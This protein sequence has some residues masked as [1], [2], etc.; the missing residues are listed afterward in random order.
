ML[1]L[2]PS[3]TA[4]TK[5]PE[6]VVV[7][8]DGFNLYYG[9]REK[10]WKHLYW[11]NLRELILRLQK[12]NQFLS[13]VKYFTTRVS[14]TPSD[15]DKP[16]RQK[17]FL[18]ALAT[19]PDMELIYGHYLEKS[20]TCR[21]CGYRWTIHE[22]K[23]T[24]VN[25]AVQMLQDAQNDLFDTAFLVSADSD[26]FGPVQAIRRGYLTKRVVVAFPPARR[27]A[28][29][30]SIAHAHLVI[31]RAQLTKSQFPDQV[32]KLDGFVLERPEQWKQPINLKTNVKTE[33]SHATH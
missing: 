8:I 19:L 20:V 11:L 33:D 25:I 27:S 30:K 16:V 2:S 4:G 23:M 6:R 12:P 9:L 14:A 17:A 1:K 21:N 7:Y 3:P 15:P 5:D 18:E 31:G 29:L 32:R 22:E 13:A 28:R 24:D 10:G 26:L